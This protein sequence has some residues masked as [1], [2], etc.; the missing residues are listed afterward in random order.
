MAIIAHIGL[1]SLGLQPVG[2]SWW[3]NEEK[4]VIYHKS[5][6][7]QELSCNRGIGSS[8]PESKVDR[9]WSFVHKELWNLIVLCLI[10]GND[11][12]NTVS[13][14]N[15]SASRLHAQTWS[16][17]RHMQTSESPAPVRTG[18][19]LMNGCKP[20]GPSSLGTWR[21]LSHCSW[22]SQK[23]VLAE[24]SGIQCYGLSRVTTRLCLANKLT[25]S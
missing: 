18:S 24:Q 2:M 10:W 16:N 17:L 5:P 21:M 20:S 23:Q 14:S 25:K 13:A 8:N 6:E 22:A 19:E 9:G 12:Q 4:W 11:F 1:R 15:H 3:C 7:D